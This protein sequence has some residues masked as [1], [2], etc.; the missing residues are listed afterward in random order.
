[1][2]DLSALNVTGSDGLG[3]LRDFPAP[4]VR[5]RPGGVLGTGLKAAN[6]LGLNE[7]DQ[8][9]RKSEDM[10][11][12]VKGVV[13]KP[14]TFVRKVIWTAIIVAVIKELLERGGICGGDIYSVHPPPEGERVGG[15]KRQ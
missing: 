5:S 14:S 12:L 2:T 3:D 10:T 6:W 1:M 8:T 15:V 4:M 7:L 9:R 13:P 11:H